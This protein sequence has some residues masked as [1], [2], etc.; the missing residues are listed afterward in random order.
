[1]ENEINRLRLELASIHASRSWKFT[2]ILRTITRSALGDRASLRRKAL[3]KILLRNT[4]QALPAGPHFTGMP[5]SLISTECTNIETA[6][7]NTCAPERLENER[8]SFLAPTGCREFL[9]LQL[10]D[11]AASDADSLPKVFGFQPFQSSIPNG[12]S[13]AEWLNENYQAAAL[14]FSSVIEGMDVVSCDVFDTVL[15][16]HNKSEAERNLDI[17]EYIINTLSTGPLS[18][19]VSH[20]DPMAL[21][22]MRNT[23][24]SRS[25]GSRRA[26]KGCREGSILEVV[27][28]MAR[29]LGGGDTL[30]EAFLHCE[31][32]YES[33]FCLEANQPLIET[34]RRFC[35]SG[36][37]V[38]LVSD[39]YLHRDHIHTLMEKVSP[40]SVN[41]VDEIYSSA[42]TILSKRSGQLFPYIIGRSGISPSR[43][44]HIGD[45]FFSD[46]QK[47]REAGINSL[48]FPITRS[49]TIMRQ[50]SLNTVIDRFD[51]IGIDAREWAKI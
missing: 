34:L 30:A 17:C 46:V 38:I 51:N 32:E 33:K 16:R 40:G 39:M 25:Y 45:S 4:A 15:L 6:N 19:H 43:T 35:E 22:L 5:P 20:I 11:P 50:L 41:Y 7:V 28:N 37:R 48:H 27:E 36:G 12:A 44:L 21:L 1:M 2:S 42:D 8:K 26:V 23:A 10:V 29:T 31:L 47:A 9:E 3:R 14:W 49:E 24:M 18:S 13:R